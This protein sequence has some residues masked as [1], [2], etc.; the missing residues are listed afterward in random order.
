[1]LLKL[2]SGRGCSLPISL[3]TLRADPAEIICSTSTVYW[4]ALGVSLHLDHVL[5]DVWQKIAAYLTVTTHTHRPVQLHL[6]LPALECPSIDRVLALRDMA[7]AVVELGN[8]RFQPIDD[9]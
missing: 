6:V 2:H 8:V 5:R 7:C 9:A 1:M 3:L 4:E